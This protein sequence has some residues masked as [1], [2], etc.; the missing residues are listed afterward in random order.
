MLPRGILGEIKYRKNLKT[1]KGL[2]CAFCADRLKE[3]KRKVLA[4]ND[5]MLLLENDFPYKKWSNLTVKKHLL[6]VP[7]RHVIKMQDMTTAEK[8]D[9]AHIMAT[10]DAMGYSFYIRSYSDKYRSIGHIHGHLFS[11]K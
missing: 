1:T 8:T 7:K 5:S 11:F 2:G 10:S 4:E 3:T 6:I 9:L